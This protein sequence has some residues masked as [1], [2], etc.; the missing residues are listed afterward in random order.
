MAGFGEQRQQLRLALVAAGLSPD[1][2]TQIANILGNSAQ[3]LRHAGPVE[4]DSTPADL[5]QVGP[6]QRKQRFLNLDFRDGD[7][8]YRPQRTA[9]SE[10]RREKEPEPNIVP[11]VAPQSTD[12]TFRVAPGSITDVAGDGRAAQVNVRNTVAGRP[13]AGLPVAMLDSQAN[14]LVGKAPRA[15]VGQNDGTARLD[16]QENGRE[17]L[18]NLQMLNRSEYDVVTKVEYISGRGLEITYERIKAW[19]QQ[20][21]RVDT[22]AVQEQAVVTELVDDKKGLRG[23]RRLIPVFESRGE[24]N[25]YFNTYR[26]GTFEDGWAIGTV[27]QITQ[28]WPTSDLVVDVINLTQEIADTPS[29]KY[30]LFAPRT[31]SAVPPPPEDEEEDPSEATEMDAP[32][33]VVTDG[34]LYDAS[35]N[36]VESAADG[37]HEPAVEYVALEIQNAQECTAFHYLDGLRVDELAGYDVDVPSALSYVTSGEGEDPCLTWRS[38]LV[39]VLTDVSL[40]AEG[41]VFSRKRLYVLGELTEEPLVI[42]VTECPTEPPPE[43]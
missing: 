11:V 35:D 16:I 9:P 24:S 40:T 8:D 14:Q 1:A 34:P 32:Q 6:E 23:R 5:R 10:E 30:V 17:V 37:V 3:G 21:G 4:V 2:A 31:E 19:D 27:K 7:P 20:A 28:V 42:S 12:A 25:T 29:T 22:I 15:Q 13:V 39:T 18:W 38:H 33:P 43:A 41:L 26:I 36:L